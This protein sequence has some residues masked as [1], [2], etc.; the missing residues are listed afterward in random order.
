MAWLQ[1]WPDP[2]RHAPAGT[3]GETYAALLERLGPV[4]PFELAALGGRA[5]ATPGQLRS[6]ARGRQMAMAEDR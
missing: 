6:T 4:A 3:L 5:M 1:R 2:L